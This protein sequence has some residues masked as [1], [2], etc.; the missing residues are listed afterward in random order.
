VPLS[1]LVAVDSEGSV[2]VAT[3]G[4]GCITAIT[5]QGVVRAVLPVPEYDP[6]VTNVCFGGEELSTAFVTSSGLGKLYAA[7]WH[8]P[9]LRLPFN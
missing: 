6:M 5:P 7:A 2:V 9:G 8:C 1:P 3:L 4:T